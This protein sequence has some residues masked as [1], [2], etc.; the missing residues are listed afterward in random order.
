MSSEPRQ[1]LVLLEKGACF[2]LAEDDRVPTLLAHD[3]IRHSVLRKGLDVLDRSE[4]GTGAQGKGRRVDLRPLVQL[5]AS[6]GRDN[7]VLAPTPRHTH[8]VFWRRDGECLIH[9][10]AVDIG[11]D[12]D[13]ACAVMAFCRG[14]E[15]QIADRNWGHGLR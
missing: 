4:A 12:L 6:L 7:D 13:G 3:Y 2:S 14:N 5:H 9:F 11:I 15:Q 8:G 1:S 10:R